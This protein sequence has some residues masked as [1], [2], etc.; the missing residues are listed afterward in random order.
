MINR[1]LIILKPDAI[2]RNLVGEIISRIEKKGLKI[3]AMKMVLLSRERA[4][5]L[6]EIHRDKKFFNDLVNYI[7]SGPVIAMIV[8]GNDVINVVRKLMGKTN[9]AEAEPGTIR[10][11]YSTSIEKNLI[12][13]SDSEESFKREMPVFFTEEEI[14]KYTKMDENWIK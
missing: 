14:I 5:K 11:D 2:Q 10:G 12:H 8:E 7:T 9:G 1:T 6:Y 3:T 13:G 4:E